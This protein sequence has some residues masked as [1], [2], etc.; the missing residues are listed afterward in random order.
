MNTH[1]LAAK[2]E[3]YV[4][5]YLEGFGRV[6][7]IVGVDFF[8]RNVWSDESYVIFG[9]PKLSDGLK[10]TTSCE[11]ADK[12]EPWLP[13]CEVVLKD[14]Y[15]FAL[16]KFWTKVRET[17]RDLATCLRSVTKLFDGPLEEAAVARLHFSGD[18]GNQLIDLLAMTEC[19]AISDTLRK[20]DRLP[21]F[22]I[23]AEQQK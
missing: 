19:S 22:R 6:I 18:F 12:Y 11:S 4:S 2:A 9:D 21:K 5:D 1:L 14:H 3:F 23:K 10:R 8:Q 16:A 7:I 13:S 15:A 17:D 20:F